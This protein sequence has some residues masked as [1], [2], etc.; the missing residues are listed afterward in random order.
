M[1]TG[2]REPFHTGS[3]IG[4][5]IEDGR[6]FAGGPGFA[7]DSDRVM[8]CG[9]M[10]MIRELAKRFDTLGF[11]EGSNAKPGGYVI[12]RAFVG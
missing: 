10:D 12:E 2:T 5:L 3:R 6:L 9:S 1:P 8:R 4:D 11:A 7:P